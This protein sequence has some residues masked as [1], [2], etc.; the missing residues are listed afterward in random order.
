MSEMN[1]FPP[2]INS[3]KKK[4][5]KIFISE[6]KC[7]FF[8]KM[9]LVFSSFLRSSCHAKTRDGQEASYPRSPPGTVWIVVV[10]PLQM[11]EGIAGSNRGREKVMKLPLLSF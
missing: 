10:I 4:A 11:Y 2:K 6:I 9:C 8:P 1:T 5:S 3:S 7:N